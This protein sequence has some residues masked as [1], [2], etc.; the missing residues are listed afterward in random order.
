[1]EWTDERV[2]LLRE[3]WTAGYSAQQI[4]E[5]LGYT[6]RNAV[7]G[8]ANRLGLS[9]PT[10]SSITRKQKEQ[11]KDNTALK[12][13]QGKSY[14]EAL[15]NLRKVARGCPR[16]LFEDVQDGQCHVV[17]AER[18]NKRFCCGRATLGSRDQYCE[19][20]KRMMKKKVPK[21]ASRE[22]LDQEAEELSK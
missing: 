18:G 1:M 20:H 8:K 6:S 15:V 19:K 2:T 16:I 3:M 21:R 22:V 10:K 13:V 4:V 14:E 17:V 12:E 5:K 7:I 9:K 11:H